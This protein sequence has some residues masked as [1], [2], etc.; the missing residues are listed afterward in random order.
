MN[1]LFLEKPK[2]TEEIDPYTISSLSSLT[3]TVTSERLKSRESKYNESFPRI[4]PQWIKFD[5]QV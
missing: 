4:L 1:Y 5:K 3:S 2:Y